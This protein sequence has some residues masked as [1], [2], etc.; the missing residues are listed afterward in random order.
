VKEDVI[1][2]FGELGVTIKGGEIHFCPGLL[3]RDEFVTARTEFD[4]YDVGGV[5]Q[6]MLLK[7]GELAFTYCQVPVVFRLARVNS[8][9]VVLMNGARKNAEQLRL[10]PTTSR[11]IFQRTGKVARIEVCFS[12]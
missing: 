11:E 4:F 1:S 5:R 12:I 9:I 6:R 10:D 7:P 8:L 2:R 3:R